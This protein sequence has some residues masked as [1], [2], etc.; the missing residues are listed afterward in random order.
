MT[1]Y[2]TKPLI[3]LT[4]TILLFCNTLM[5]IAKTDVNTISFANAW[6]TV[7]VHNDAIAAA[8]AHID[9]AGHNRDAAKDLYLPEIGI[10]ASYIYLDDDV[11]LTPTDLLESMPAGQQLL[12]AVAGLG[13][14]YGLSAAA[15]NSGLT[16]TIAERENLTSS[17]NGKWPIYAGGRIDA[18][19]DIAGGKFKE[20][21]RQKDMT[22]QQQFELLVHYYFGAVLAKQ[23]LD[24]RINVEK[25]LK[26]HRD[27]AILLE[28]QG[29]IARVERLQSA[30]SYDKAKVES[31]KASRD[32]E[33]AT[34]AL[35][36]ML[37]S[38]GNVTPADSLFINNN[39]PSLESFIEKT[40]THHPGLGILDSKKEQAVGLIKVEKGK[41]LPTAALFG[42]YSLY[43]EDDLAS[44]LTPDWLVGVGVKI[45]LF[46]RSGRSGKLAAAK[47]MVKQIYS[48]QL[49]TRSDLSVLVEKTYRQANQALE[50]YLGLGSSLE[51]AEE[52][53]KLRV[54]AFSQGLS[55]SL[56]V[57]DAEL[58]LAGVR[59]QRSVAVYNYVTALAKL[60][61]VSG[62]L[63]DFF[64]YQTEQGIEVQ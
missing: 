49:Q 3:V 38:E 64:L 4:V 40:I 35:T 10:S 18:A 45:P 7:A 24:T 51:L 56:D 33:I 29:Q 32:L 17:I 55:T 13:Q 12:P 48:L 50:E 37:K 2:I 16:S 62:A 23:I 36:R 43:E 34:V 1:T 14:S 41:Y 5:A 11:T 21:S 52:T 28:N 53:V 8:Q 60:L 22:V 61:A 19:Q 15:L 25:G 39:I 59:A 57:V 20:A 58:F 44:K 54:K 30:A 42:N 6:E 46:E 31:R 26:T 47:S 63:G 27:H 9:E